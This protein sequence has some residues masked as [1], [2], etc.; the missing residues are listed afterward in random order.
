MNADGLTEFLHSRIPLTAAMGLRVLPGGAQEIEIRAP[1]A[2][3]INV[4]QT[5]FG[6][7]LVT[8]A[9]VAA[10]TLLHRALEQAQVVCAV[11]VQKSE[12]EYLLPARGELCASGRLPEDGWREFLEGLQRD[13]RGRIELDITVSSDG[14][15]C[16]RHRG[17]FVAKATSSAE[18]KVKS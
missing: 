6:G 5:A 15:A 16:A 3:N 8:L 4:H 17:S 9:I 7:S 18:A 10:W 14:A 1:L 12:C 11:F 2:P 13:G